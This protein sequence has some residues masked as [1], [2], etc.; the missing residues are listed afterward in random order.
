MSYWRKCSVQ[1][2]RITAANGIVWFVG[3]YSLW[4]PGS[5]KTS[6]QRLRKPGRIDVV[7]KVKPLVAAGKPQAAQKGHAREKDPPGCTLH[8]LSTVV[9]AIDVTVQY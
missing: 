4:L 1:G 5:R 3:A 2:P 7:R 9:L 8:L 6:L